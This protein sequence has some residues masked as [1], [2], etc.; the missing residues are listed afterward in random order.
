MAVAGEAIFSDFSRQTTGA[1][2]LELFLSR[3]PGGE[4]RPARANVGRPSGRRTPPNV[5]PFFLSDSLA[6]RVKVSSAVISILCNTRF[7]V[8]V[9]RVG[10]THRLRVALVSRPCSSM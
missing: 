8:P 1:R 6:A 7:L 3:S 5:T 2:I 10:V 4:G 9:T